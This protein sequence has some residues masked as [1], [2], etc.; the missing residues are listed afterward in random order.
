[1]K[2][3]CVGRNYIAHAEELNNPVPDEPLIFIK[4]ATAL[5][6]KNR[7][8]YYPA[9]TENLHYE[10]ELV[11]K[12]CKNG[13]YVQPEF[14]SDHYDSIGFGIDFTARDIQERLKKAGH[15][16]ELS[17]AFDQS[18]AVSDF[19]P[20]EKYQSDSIHFHLEKNGEVVQEGNTSQL[21]YN[22]TFLITFISTYFKLLTGDLIFTGTPAGVGPV[23]R[24]DVLDGFI[25]GEH[26]I[27]CKIK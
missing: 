24:E 22:F 14:A 21:I 4:P 1:M 10:G 2:I 27:T 19:T 8:L 11:L 25:E 13:K 5:L 6:L 16:W 9:F 17:K 7:P 18:A 20:I 15:P 23:T 26:L 3:F 12:I